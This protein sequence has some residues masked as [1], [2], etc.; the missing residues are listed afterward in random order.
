MVE[1]CQGATLLPCQ[2][3]DERV[4]GDATADPSIREREHIQRAPQR[5]KT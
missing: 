2:S 5:G 4:W 1:S 3:H